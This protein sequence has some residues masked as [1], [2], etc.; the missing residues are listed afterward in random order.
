MIGHPSDTPPHG[1]HRYR[2]RVYYEDS[3]AAGIV[4]HANF[5]RFAERART[6][7]LRDLGVPHAS[8]VRE[9]GIMFLVR[10]VKMEYLRPARVDDLLVVTTTLVQAG[11]ASVVLRQDFERDGEPNDVLVRTEVRLACVGVADGRAAR[12][13]AAWRHALARLAA[14]LEGE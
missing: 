13:P 6:E 2:I 8:M 12:L 5:L 10:R 1:A 4:Y 11:G 14:P 3:D 7:A 9:H